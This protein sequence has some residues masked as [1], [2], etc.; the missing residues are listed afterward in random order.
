MRLNRDRKP[1]VH[2]G[3]VLGNITFAQFGK[4]KEG[5]GAGVGMVE[6]GDAQQ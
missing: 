4:G 2:Q 3:P 5:E 1:P 6:L